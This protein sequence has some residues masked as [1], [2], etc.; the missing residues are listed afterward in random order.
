VSTSL[1]G[2]TGRACGNTTEE[3]L[4]KPVIY[5]SGVIALGSF[6]GLILVPLLI[7]DTVEFAEMKIFLI[8]IPL[9][10]PRL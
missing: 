3:K 4:I 2:P 5:R 6:A 7:G 10:E 1:A 8:L 9:K